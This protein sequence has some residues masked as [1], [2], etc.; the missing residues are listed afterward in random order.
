MM[1][2]HMYMYVHVGGWVCGG[3]GRED[4]G[5]TC[6]GN[7]LVRKLERPVYLTSSTSYKSYTH[8]PVP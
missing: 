7:N 3:G 2:T 1:V 6:G 8:P 5:G 4:G